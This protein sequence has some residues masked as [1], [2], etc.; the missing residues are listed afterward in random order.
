M[1]QQLLYPIGYSFMSTMTFLTILFAQLQRKEKE[2][3]PINW[4]VL[5]VISFLT[6]FA[7][8]GTV[9]VFLIYK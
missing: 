4:S 9:V 1:T 8:T 2:N 5:K 7:W 6:A 3:H